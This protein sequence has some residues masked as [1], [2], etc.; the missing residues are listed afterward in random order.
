MKASF[1]NIRSLY[2]ANSISLVFSAGKD[3]SSSGV[4]SFDRYIGSKKEGFES[5]PRASCAK[6]TRCGSSGSM[7]L[8]APAIESREAKEGHRETSSGNNGS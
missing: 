6:A 1:R 7:R 5:G 2:S 8:K 4:E 3:S